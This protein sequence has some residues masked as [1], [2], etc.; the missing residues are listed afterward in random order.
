MLV[1]CKACKKK[2]DRN[3]AFKVRK[4]N[5]NNYYCNEQEYNRKQLELESRKKVID[6]SL[7][8]CGNT[9]N[10]N[11]MKELNDISKSHGYVK[12]A[13]YIEEH[14]IEIDKAMS[15]KYVSDFAMIRYYAAILKN[16]LGDYVPT[17]DQEDT[18]VNV[19]IIEDVKYKSNDK[20]SFFDMFA[21]YEE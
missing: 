11:L 17:D 21:E 13:K 18:P 16:S 4:N 9:T 1:G 10:T 6:L 2:I 8:L 12:M 5:V 19:D 7:E 15:M 14:M 20:K 3:V